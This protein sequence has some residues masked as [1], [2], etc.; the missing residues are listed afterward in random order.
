[1]QA[2]KNET[3]FTLIELVITIV[4]AGIIT[5]IAVPSFQTLI[6]NNRISTSA[7]TFMTAL[8]LARSEAIKRA[9]TIVLSS[10]SGTTSWESGWKIKQGATTIRD[11]DKLGPGTVLTATA[12]T[13]TFDSRGG[14]SG[15]SS[16]SF[17]L[18]DDRTG[19]KGI[20][21][22]LNVTGRPDSSEYNCS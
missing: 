6:K 14:L 13:I 21:I 7:N 9:S 2:R 8:N 4:L 20:A 15:V 1:M 22:T 3:G 10:D 18:C 17:N 19:E 12:N 16:F 5:V 11:Y